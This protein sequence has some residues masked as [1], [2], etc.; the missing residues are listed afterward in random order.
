MF[1]CWSILFIDYWYSVE[2]VPEILWQMPLHRRWREVRSWQSSWSQ[3]RR[4]LEPS[5]LHWLVGTDL[6]GKGGRRC[7]VIFRER[8][9]GFLFV[10]T[11]RVGGKSHWFEKDPRLIHKRLV[12]QRTLTFVR[13]I[14]F[15]K[16][17]LGRG[18]FSGKKFLAESVLILWDRH[19]EW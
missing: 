8:N 3:P 18:M 13:E 7:G 12:F 2:S 1:F 15:L 11:N 10:R 17:H 14:F 19:L 4:T 16:T 5:I 9:R 6:E